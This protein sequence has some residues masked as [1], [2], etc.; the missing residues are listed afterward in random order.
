[1]IDTCVNSIAKTADVRRSQRPE[2]F[3]SFAYWLK[4]SE[5]QSEVQTVSSDVAGH[6]EIF[7]SVTDEQAKP[8]A[9]LEPCAGLKRTLQALVRR[10][11]CFAALFYRICVALA[12]NE[13]AAADRALRCPLVPTIV[14]V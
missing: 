14:R 3:S 4:N 11:T 2:V 12:V 13:Q 7:R 10:G 9:N 6:D 1:M 8:Q 5:Q